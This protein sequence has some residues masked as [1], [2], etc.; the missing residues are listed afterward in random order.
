MIFCS[1]RLIRWGEGVWLNVGDVGVLVTSY[2]KT[3]TKNSVMLP[4]IQ[5]H[6]FFAKRTQSKEREY[7]PH[8]KR[9]TRTLYLIESVNEGK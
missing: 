5:L 8:D 7:V 9:G 3:P 6:S 1:V 4:E 2:N